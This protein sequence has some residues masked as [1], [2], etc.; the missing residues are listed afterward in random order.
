[1]LTQI[2]I[3]HVA[4]MITSPQVVMLSFLVKIV[5]WQARK[6]NIVARSNTEYEY[7]SLANCASKVIW[8]QP[9]L[10][11]IGVFLS[12][13]PILWCDNIGATYLTT[14]SLYARTKH[15][16]AEFH[17][18]RMKNARED[19]DVHFISTKSN[20]PMCLPQLCHLIYFSC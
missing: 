13:A 18:V 19:L 17:F 4:P 12:H 11:E 16:E 9:L 20:L 5:S 1:M 6:Q 14:N 3:G 2:L 8:I 7:R 15:I 10:K